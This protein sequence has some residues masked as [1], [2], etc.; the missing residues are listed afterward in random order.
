V[1]K[2]V[3]IGEIVL[4][5]DGAGKYH[6]AEVTGDYQYDPE[7]VLVHQRPVRW[8]DTTLERSRMSEALKNGSGWP[9]TIV[10]LDKYSSEIES[11]IA[12]VQVQ[13]PLV[14]SN[15]YEVQSPSS[16]AL[17]KHL[18][19]FM[20]ANWSQTELGRDYNIYEEDG[21]RLG[22]QYPS[23]TGPMDILAVSKDNKRLLVVELKLGR[24]NDC[25]VGQVLRYMSYKDEI[26][27]PGQEV[28]GVVIGLEDDLRLKRALSM[29]P[30]LSFYRYEVNFKLFKGE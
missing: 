13:S 22:K 3:K 25:V 8:L 28:H 19:D 16:F 11:L 9:Q 27:E 6:I 1:S 4:C 14:T 7:S 24:P 10:N 17:E 2:G 15:T 21:V 12:G 26:A 23:D 20:V 29:V 30:N 5:P 18:E